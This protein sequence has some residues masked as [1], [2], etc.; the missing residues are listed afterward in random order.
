MVP[1]VKL[2]MVNCRQ[3]VGSVY[4]CVPNEGFSTEKFEEGD[5][6]RRPRIISARQM[7]AYIVSAKRFP[8]LTKS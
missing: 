2:L 3:I 8:I 4:A 1:N 7:D 6:C 5:S